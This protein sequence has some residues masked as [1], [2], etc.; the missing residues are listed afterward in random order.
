MFEIANADVVG[1]EEFAG[2][3]WDGGVAE[4]IFVEEFVHGAE[5]ENVGVEEADAFVGVG[6]QREDLQF[7][8]GGGEAGGDA[9]VGAEV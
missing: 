4:R 7:G 9:G 8:P 1:G 5:N 6:V 2:F 3:S